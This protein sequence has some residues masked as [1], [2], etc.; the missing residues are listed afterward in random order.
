MITLLA[1]LWTA[2]ARAEPHLGSDLAELFFCLGADCE[3]RGSWAADPYGWSNPATM[4]AGT[5]PFVARGVFLTPPS[6]FHLNAGGVSGDVLLPSLAVAL[7]PWVFEV[8]FAYA[9]ASGT[10][11]SLPGTDLHSRTRQLRLG[12][13]L[14]L[15][16]T[17]AAIS[18]LSA[19][20]RFGVP[21]TTTDARL[22]AAGQSF[23]V[24]TDERDYDFN[25]GLLWRWGKLDWLGVGATFEVLRDSVRREAPG[26]AS[27]PAIVEHGATN[28]WYARSGA[29][30]LPFVPLGL[31]EPSSPALSLLGRVRLGA[32]LEYRNILAAGEPLRE[33]W[34]GYFGADVPLL[35]EPWKP[36]ADYLQLWL[37]S[38]VD[39][40]TGYGLGVGL[41]GNG[42]AQFIGCAGAYSSRPLAPSLGDRVDVWATTCSLTLPL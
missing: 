11:R 41:Y 33:R 34:V 25:P 14:D 30:L 4:T 31:A 35:P 27:S 26:Q 16:R 21:G 3:A 19:G 9:E 6:W 37:I 2:P 10:P 40:D 38:G 13:A 1:L 24:E 17:A 36:I 29:S 7:D 23:L 32:D 39:T 28:A 5:L 20:L 8:D 15:G 42:P 12:A 18:G 22:L